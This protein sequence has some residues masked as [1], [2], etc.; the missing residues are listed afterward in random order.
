MLCSGEIGT[1]QR[2]AS[3][4]LCA[5]KATSIAHIGGAYEREII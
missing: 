2:A 5:G 4:T 3:L 1:L